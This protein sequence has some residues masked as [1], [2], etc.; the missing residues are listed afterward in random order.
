MSNNRSAVEQFRL[1]QLGAINYMIFLRD[2]N[3]P[4]AFADW[5]MSDSTP[6]KALVIVRGVNAGISRKLN[7]A[8]K[9]IKKSIVKPST[10]KETT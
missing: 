6:E 2:A 10:A 4:E 5:L 8:E 1:D 9:H 7:A 3:S